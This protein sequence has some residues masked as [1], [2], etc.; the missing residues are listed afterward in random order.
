[1]KH[2]VLSRFLLCMVFAICVLIVAAIALKSSKST[3]PQ[4]IRQEQ[5]IQITN[6]TESLQVVRTKINESNFVVEVQNV[7]ARP[8][9]GYWFQYGE[10]KTNTQGRELGLGEAFQ[11]GKTETMDIPLA[12]LRSAD[13]NDNALRLKLAVCMFEDLSAEGDWEI[14]RR[15][16][17]AYQGAAVAYRIMRE[18][19]EPLSQSASLD[20]SALQAASD[21]VAALNV[22][23]DLTE[24]QRIGFQE[25]IIHMRQTLSVA[26]KN[27]R[28]GNFPLHTFR[29][30]VERS[31]ERGSRFE[32]R[33]KG[34]T[35]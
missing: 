34:V 7:G 2:P 29:R 27:S 32:M 25:G 17:E 22:P 30:N 14:A 21:R 26:A 13:A 3:N 28:A 6:E 24:N 31:I 12:N 10:D 15:N 19:V 1:M 8:V 23:N 35:R 9:V 20:P 4:A 18:E 11:P 33:R 16:R 5:A